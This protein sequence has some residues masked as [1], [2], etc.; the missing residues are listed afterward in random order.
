MFSEEIVLFW[1]EN[2]QDC[3]KTFRYQ[4]YRMYR[5]VPLFLARIEGPLQKF[6]TEVLCHP[7]RVDSVCN[8]RPLVGLQALQRYDLIL[9][10]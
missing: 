7:Q 4:V 2:K 1:I 6:Q 9:F 5:T 10:C 3:M 8:K